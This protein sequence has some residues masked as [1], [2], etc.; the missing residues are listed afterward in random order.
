[1][2]GQENPEL[3]YSCRHIKITAIYR[4]TIYEHELKSNKKD[5]PQLNIHQKNLKEMGRRSETWYSQD[6]YA[7]WI[8]TIAEAL[9]HN[10]GV[11]ASHCIPHASCN[12]K[13]SPPECLALKASGGHVAEPVSKP[14]TALPTGHPPRSQPHPSRRAPRANTGALQSMLPW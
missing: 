10:R 2:L 3:I 4:A 1:M 9:P 8:T 5:F 13:T 14:R 11:Q 7:W 6:L 12:G